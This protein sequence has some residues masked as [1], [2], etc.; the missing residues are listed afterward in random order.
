MSDVVFFTVPVTFEEPVPHPGARVPPPELR[1]QA[2]GSL[3]P[4]DRK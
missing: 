4:F 2:S 3:V 1:V